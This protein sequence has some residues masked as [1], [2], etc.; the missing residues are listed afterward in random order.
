MEEEEL[1]LNLILENYIERGLITINSA[2]N[3]CSFKIGLIT[4]VFSIANDI[5]CRW[6]LCI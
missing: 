4:E 1:Y 2:G 3:M 6:R 5:F